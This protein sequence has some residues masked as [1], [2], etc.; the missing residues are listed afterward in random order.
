M[1][2]QTENIKISQFVA[3][4]T[5]LVCKLLEE[6]F[7]ILD[8]TST[9]SGEG[10]NTVFCLKKD[11]KELRFYLSNLLIEITTTDRDKRPLQFDE[12]L[13]DFKFFLEKTSSI[14]NSKLI[15]LLNILSHDDVEQAVDSITELSKNYERISIVQFDNPENHENQNS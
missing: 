2:Q 13:N 12:N 8:I 11:D 14:I 7:C 4:V 9:Q 10:Y 5:P 6:L 3:F 15:I 1:Y